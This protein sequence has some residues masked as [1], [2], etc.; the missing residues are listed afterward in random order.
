MRSGERSRG[1]V[2]GLV[3]IMR[4]RPTIVSLTFDDGLASQQAAYSVLE[5]HDTRGTFFVSSRLIGRPGHLTWAEVDRFAA[6]GHEL[7]G[8]TADHVDLT[9]VPRATAVDQIRGDRAALLERGLRT[10]SF[11][12]PFGA[13]NDVVKRI[14][15]TSGYNSARRAW[16]LRGPR[17]PRCPA[18]ERIPPVDPYATR[19]A[20]NAT[21]STRLEDL[22]RVVQLA[23]R[24]SGRWLQLVFHGLGDAGAYS[25]TLSTFSDFVAWLA[26]RRARGTLTKTVDEVIGGPLRPADNTAG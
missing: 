1:R 20:D 4:R 10:K 14:V 3:R 24:R 22:Q 25:T 2:R 6:G 16:G 21:P 17:C 19:T 13:R 8:H 11:A 9:A 18:A 5:A 26:D 15:A 23:E 7:G 12:Y